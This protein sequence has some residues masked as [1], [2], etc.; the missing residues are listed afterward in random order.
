MQLCERSCRCVTDTKSI[1][2]YGKFHVCFGN[3]IHNPNKIPHSTFVFPSPNVF[4]G[5]MPIFIF[6]FQG[7]AFEMAFF[8]IPQA[9]LFCL[10]VNRRLMDTA[11]S[12]RVCSLPYCGVEIDAWDPTIIIKG[13]RIR[14]G[15]HWATAGTFT[16][17]QHD[18]TKHTVFGGEA[19][20]LARFVA[21]LAGPGQVFL[22]GKAWAKLRQKDVLRQ[23]GYPI[24]ESIGVYKI[25]DSALVSPVVSTASESHLG[26]KRRD[27]TSTN[28]DCSSYLQLYQLHPPLYF[29]IGPRQT[30]H[31]LSQKLEV[32]RMPRGFNL[33]LPPQS[34]N[35][36]IVVLRIA[37]LITVAE[38]SNSEVFQAVKKIVL[39][40]AQMYQ[41][42]VSRVRQE[43]T[44]LQ[45]VFPSVSEAVRFAM[46]TQVALVYGPWQSTDDNTL[47][48]VE[49]KNIDGTTLLFRGPRVAMAVHVGDRSQYSIISAKELYRNNM[50]QRMKV[51][52][53][54]FNSRQSRRADHQHHHHYYATPQQ[55][56]PLVPA[57]MQLKR[58]MSL[59]LPRRDKDKT[60]GHIA[61]FTSSSVSVRSNDD[62]MSDLLPRR[63][64]KR[65]TQSMLSVST[66]QSFYR[67]PAPTANPAKFRS[68]SAKNLL[69]SNQ[70]T[71]QSHHQSSFSI[72]ALN[73]FSRALFRGK[74]TQDET[75]HDKINKTEGKFT[76]SHAT[77]PTS[78]STSTA[79]KSKASVF[80]ER[81]AS[82]PR[83]QRRDSLTQQHSDPTPTPTQD[84]PTLPPAHRPEL[85][86]HSLTFVSNK[87]L[88]TN[89]S[90]DV[91]MTPRKKSASV[92][93]IGDQAHDRMM[94]SAPEIGGVT[95]K[96]VTVVDSAATAHRTGTT[97]LERMR[98][99]RSWRATTPANGLEAPDEL[100]YQ[101]ELVDCGVLLCHLA[102]GGQ[103][104]LSEQAWE[105]VSDNLPSQTQVIHLGTFQF[106]F[107]SSLQTLNLMEL[108]PLILAQRQFP[109]V[110]SI[111]CTSPG[112]RQ[113]P[114]ID[115][116][117]AIVFCKVFMPP[118][119]TAQQVTVFESELSLWSRICRDLLYHYHGYECKEPDPGKFTLAFSNPSDAVTFCCVAQRKLLDANWSEELLQI[120]EFKEVLE[121]PLLS[122]QHTGSILSSMDRQVRVWRGLRVSMGFAFGKPTFRKPLQ[123]T[124]RADYFGP[125]PN[126]SARVLGQAQP[127]QV[128]F[129]GES[130]DL[131]VRY[132]NGHATMSLDGLDE[133][134]SLHVIGMSKLKGIAAEKIM[135]EASLESLKQRSF[136]LPKSYVSSAPL[137]FTGAP[138]RSEVLFKMPTILLRHDIGHTPELSRRATRS[139]STFAHRQLTQPL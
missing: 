118:T 80:N 59:T 63:Q 103:T 74:Y 38:S 121:D 123:S 20:E 4:V 75:D 17:K 16:V 55:E 90:S 82:L 12:V 115:K 62:L 50:Q 43:P 56:Q 104:M 60:I 84:M 88:F 111:Q 113:S 100:L 22:T 51:R 35:V 86:Q 36:A 105:E 66:N 41:G 138:R 6:F 106:R 33:A 64:L 137:S 87:P 68:K 39:F 117:M 13:P 70:G 61:S 52:S 132:A 89:S 26:S 102:H 110:P 71:N 93:E 14:M 92:S 101:G 69:S 31:E 94:S 25:L 125:L 37:G 23:A 122:L 19:F 18:L 130:L 58:S 2:R 131:G 95:F 57:E 127:G 124:G 10:H 21:E 119:L 27:S 77:S 112:Y 42:Y 81:S 116:G 133:R 28:S 29:R 5:W 107:P 136:T 48:G 109:P 139:N 15:I 99:L 32:V 65:D 126:L 91:R 129:D 85:Q 40:V 34:S 3:A 53:S 24:V 7:D 114:A 120:E 79:P 135:V 8:T 134:I 45:V 67:S 76:A 73:R 72:F 46:T 11:W 83:F 98:S 96:Q 97:P 9:V 47:F 44:L 1:H 128:L 108:S 30:T 49:E 78:S 54:F